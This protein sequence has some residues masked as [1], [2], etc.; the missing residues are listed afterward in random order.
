MQKGQR[1]SK[2][3]QQIRS[4]VRRGG[5]NLDSNVELRRLVKQATADQVPKATIERA[6][7]SASASSGKPLID[8]TYA[9]SGPHGSIFI[10][11]TL[12]DNPRRAANELRRVLKKT[13]WKLIDDASGLL[14]SFRHRAVVIACKSRV[15][16]AETDAIEA[17]AEDV[18]RDESNPARYC[19]T[20]DPAELRPLEFALQERGYEIE[21]AA[22]EY[23][24][25]RPLQLADD[26]AAEVRGVSEK[27]AELDDVVATFDNSA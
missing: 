11:E 10:I 13:A 2:Y 1:N 5:T 6:L 19:F 25:L 26:A 12:C 15:D 27:I 3:S 20:A 17:G 8:R 14:Y 16:D 4:L 23:V 7:T 22:N 24:P 9:A 18:E 21:S